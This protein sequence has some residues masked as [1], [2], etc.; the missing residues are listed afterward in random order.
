MISQFRMNIIEFIRHKDFLNDQ[1]LSATQIICLK[2]IY[3][4]ALTQGELEIFQQ[5]TG[6]TSYPRP[7]SAK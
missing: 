5:G 2:S 3:G 7:S 6:K 4:L 1:E